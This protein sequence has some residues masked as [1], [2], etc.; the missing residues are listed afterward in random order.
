[1]QSTATLE[2]ISFLHTVPHGTRTLPVIQPLGGT[3][4]KAL[5][6]S[7]AKVHGGRKLASTL[8]SCP[9]KS[10]GRWLLLDENSKQY[11]GKFDTEKEKVVRRGEKNTKPRQILYLTCAIE[12]S[13][14]LAPPRQKGIRLKSAVP[15]V[16]TKPIKRWN[17][18][19][20]HNF[21]ICLLWNI[22]IYYE[23]CGRRICNS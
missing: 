16:V 23:K 5:N 13:P 6:L 22:K 4:W 10:S 7:H 19:N 17:H 12:S 1:M 8:V 14:V 21:I 3:H 20:C 11:S 15:T 18:W 9:E 2:H